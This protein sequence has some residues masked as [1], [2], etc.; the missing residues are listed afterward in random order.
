MHLFKSQCLHEPPRAVSVSYREPA[1]GHRQGRRR[2]SD[3]TPRVAGNDDGDLT[4][5]AGRELLRRMADYDCA[6]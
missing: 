2:D 3:R 4:R 5:E 1:F 6:A